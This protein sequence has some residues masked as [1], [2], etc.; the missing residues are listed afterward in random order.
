MSDE[1]DNKSQVNL[2]RNGNDNE[3]VNGN[4]IG[5][6]TTTVVEHDDGKNKKDWVKFDD[7][8]SNKNKVQVREHVCHFLYRVTFM[9]IGC[10]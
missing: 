9:E 5:I 8:D 7:D 4:P 10:A 2:E 3:E 1:I 6:S